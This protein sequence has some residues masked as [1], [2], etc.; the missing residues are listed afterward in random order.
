MHLTHLLNCF[1]LDHYHFDFVL[2]VAQASHY[3]SAEAVLD[4]KGNFPLVYLF[5]RSEVRQS[6]NFNKASSLA[7]RA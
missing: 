1:F 3:C 5:V 4:W 7:L 2:I 6:L